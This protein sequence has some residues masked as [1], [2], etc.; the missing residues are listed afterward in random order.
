VAFKHNK[1]RNIGLLTEFVAQHI[2]HCVLMQN[3]VGVDKAIVLWKTALK[4]GTEMNKEFHAFNALHTSRFKNK[5]IAL[6]L[7]EQVKTHVRKLDNKK[8]EAEKNTFIQNINF[9]LNDPEFWNRSINEYKELASIQ[10]LLN[11]WKGQ[12]SLLEGVAEAASLEE[13]VLSWLLRERK[14]N[15]G[16]ESYLSMTQDDINGLAYQIMTKKFNAKY[17]STLNE[18]QK[19]IIKLYFGGSDTHKNELVNK[20]SEIKQKALQIFEEAKSNPDFKKPLLEK[21]DNIKG[22]LKEYDTNSINETTIKMYM[23][24]SKFEKEYFHG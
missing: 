2:S 11:H 19:E 3:E 6:K 17:E 12:D 9:K 1:K 10:I 21:L 24:V 20:L 8:L 16:D 4:P 22:I 23:I 5:E 7:M 13:T 18:D 14:E 15:E